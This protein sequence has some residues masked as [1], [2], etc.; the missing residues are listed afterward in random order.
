M[1]NVLIF[2]GSGKLGSHCLRKWITSKSS[3][4]FYNIDPQVSS[5]LSSSLINLDINLFTQEGRNKLIHFLVQANPVYIVNF[6]G[7]DFPRLPNSPSYLTP[8]IND[9]AAL[10]QSWEINAL[11]PYII[12]QCIDESCLHDFNMVSLSSIYAVKVPPSDLYSDSSTIFKPVAYGMMKSSLERLSKEASVYFSTRNGRSNLLRLGGVDLG[13]SEDFKIRYSQKSPSNSMVR[14]N[15][16]FNALSY[17]LFDSPVDL[18][19]CIISVDSA[20]SNVF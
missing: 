9:Y 16:V 10:Q 5:I 15:S 4:H 19:G 1:T 18:N 8:F 11:L 7:Y 3:F 12:L 17:L 2:G 13:I 14:I 20:F 6:A